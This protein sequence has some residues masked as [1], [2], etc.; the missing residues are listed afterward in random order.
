MHGRNIQFDPNIQMYALYAAAGA[1][2]KREPTP[3]N[4]VV[5]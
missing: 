2:A 4:H 3:S 1:E 5:R